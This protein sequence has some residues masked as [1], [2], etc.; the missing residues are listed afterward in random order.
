LQVFQTA[1]KGWGVRSW[2]TIPAGAPV[3]QYAGILMKSEDADNI[4]DSQ[5][6]FE[7]DCLQT[8]KGI[9]SRQVSHFV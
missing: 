7:L 8:I 1:Q 2:D 5:F 4:S 6:I 3:C 9:G